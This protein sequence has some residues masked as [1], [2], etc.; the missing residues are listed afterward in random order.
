MYILFTFDDTNFT[1][2]LKDE[3]GVNIGSAHVYARADY[4]IPALTQK[5]D[6]YLVVYPQDQVEGQFPWT[7]QFP[8]DRVVCY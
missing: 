8:R 1:F 5:D 2:Q 7:A 4:K 3:A 6:K